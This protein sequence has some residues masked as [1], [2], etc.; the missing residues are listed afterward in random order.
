MVLSLGLVAATERLS[1][2]AF[3]TGYFLGLPRFLTGH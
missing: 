1:G 2:S 3:G